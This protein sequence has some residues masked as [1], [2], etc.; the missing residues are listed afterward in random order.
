[1]KTILL[2]NFEM[3]FGKYF[4]KCECA[5]MGFISRCFCA[6]FSSGFALHQRS[7]SISIRGIL[8]VFKSIIIW[9]ASRF[10]AIFASRASR[11]ASLDFYELYRTELRRTK[12]PN[13]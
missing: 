7:K 10:P 8:T 1:M 11:L 4:I 3:A 9:E 12:Q 2:R 6:V 13:R 5:V